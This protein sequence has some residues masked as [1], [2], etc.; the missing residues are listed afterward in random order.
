[1]VV[2]HR[3]AQTV[4]ASF[5]ALIIITVMLVSCRKG[6][7]T[8]QRLLVS[9]NVDRAIAVAHALPAEEREQAADILSAYAA[10]QQGVLTAKDLA[11]IHLAVIELSPLRPEAY[12]QLGITVAEHGGL[13]EPAAAGIE[14]WQKVLAVYPELQ[15][16]AEFMRAGPLLRAG[17]S[18]VPP[19][20]LARL[21]VMNEL[22]TPKP[23]TSLG[24]WGPDLYIHHLFGAAG[25]FL[26]MTVEGPTCGLTGCVV[27]LADMSV[28]W[29]LENCV[30]AAVSGV[31]THV[32]WVSCPEGGAQGTVHVIDTRDGR[33]SSL[34][35][36]ALVDRSCHIAWSP[37]GCTVAITCRQG[38]TLFDVN[39][40]S[41]RVLAL[42]QQLGDSELFPI[43]VHWLDSGRKLAV[44]LGGPWLGTPAYAEMD[45]IR[46]LEPGSGR[47]E[48]VNVDPLAWS[49]GEAVW[50]PRTG[51]LACSIGPSSDRW[52]Q[53]VNY[54]KAT[55]AD[56]LATYGDVRSR[57]LGW[58]PDGTRLL[59]EM[60]PLQDETG[61]SCLWVW[62]SVSHELTLVSNRAHGAI[63]GDD[64]A[65]YWKAVEHDSW[66]GQ[67]MVVRF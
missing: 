40:R 38:V 2:G 50:S 60:D 4:L 42:T 67:L 32:A 17:G 5:L 21:A 18:H 22:P 35:S 24:P 23:S 13:I 31:G 45:P 41:A 36:V 39:G 37:D 59:L 58:S 15:E 54:E 7:P 43:R 49:L 9:G 62:D 29:Y 47:I 46:V 6:P 30:S 53:I 14:Q 19:D 61:W 25:G 57:P 28:K 48:L 20:G 66:H 44:Q 65:V 51:L 3:K 33:S 56:I 16:N 1:M 34:G 55:A 12:G 8:V 11:A 27:S 10:A 26:V 63:W 52:I 64:G